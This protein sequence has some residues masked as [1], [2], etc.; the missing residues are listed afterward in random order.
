MQILIAHLI[1]DYILQSHWMAVEKVKRWWPAFC[2]AAV[3]TLVVTLVLDL[4][5]TAIVIVS[6][7]HLLIDHFRL[8]KFIPYAASFLAPP[9]QWTKW[10]D[11]QSTGHPK[12]VPV[13]LATWLMIIIDN[14][15]HLAI[16]V[17]ALN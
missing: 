1:G 5:I 12:D 13:W 17:W 7:S 15:I 6:I 4:Q 3:Y 11:C 8:A 14:T 10:S 16:L 2:H 9:K